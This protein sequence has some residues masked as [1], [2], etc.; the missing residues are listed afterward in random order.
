[1][2]EIDE[3]KFNNATGKK[4]NIAM[5]SLSCPNNQKS[6]NEFDYHDE[7]TFKE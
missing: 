6:S 5:I 7:F 1:M 4:K 2:D 3:T